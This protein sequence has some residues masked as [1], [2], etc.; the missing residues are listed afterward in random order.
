M[1]SWYHLNSA[2]VWCSTQ[3]GVNTRNRPHSNL[4]SKESSDSS[5][6]CSHPWNHWRFESHENWLSVRL[7]ENW[8]F[9]IVVEC[10]E[11][12]MTCFSLYRAPIQF[13]FCF[14]LVSFI[15]IVCRNA[16]L[17]IQWYLYNGFDP[18]IHTNT[19]WWFATKRLAIFSNY[20]F[21]VVVVFVKPF[22]ECSY[23][24]SI[25]T[26]LFLTNRNEKE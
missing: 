2:I 19:Q 12:A 7:L 15:W 25:G 5:S 9:R 26:R 8:T 11:N 4:I 16:L 18:T 13:L 17:W 21:F 3:I 10:C 24:H 14:L 1:L 22:S 20:V 6:C 23:T